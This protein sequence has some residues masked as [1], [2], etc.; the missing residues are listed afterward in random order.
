[1]AFDAGDGAGFEL[2]LEN[3]ALAVDDQDAGAGGNGRDR[4]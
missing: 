1:M 2:G 3:A 4:A